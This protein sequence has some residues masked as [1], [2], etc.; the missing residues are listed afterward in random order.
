M[1]WLASG[2]HKSLV[3]PLGCLSVGLD[4]SIR[5]AT[6]DTRRPILQTL[7][8]LRFHREQRFCNEKR[9]F[10]MVF[11]FIFIAQKLINID[12]KSKTKFHVILINRQLLIL[13]IYKFCGTFRKKSKKYCKSGR[14]I[15]QVIK[16]WFN[17]HLSS[18]PSR[19]G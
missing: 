2:A 17:N 12:K 14:K 7:L 16:N 15:R 11:T 13:V 19:N 9:F 6:T 8:A 4:Y 18:D 3:R 1:R 10:T 5:P